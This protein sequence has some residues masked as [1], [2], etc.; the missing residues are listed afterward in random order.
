MGD[1]LA[2]V[3]LGSGKI[4]NQFA[5]GNGFNCMMNNDN[6]VRCFGSNDLGTLGIGNKNAVGDQ[7]N[8][9]GDNLVSI[10][11]GTSL[12]V[13]SIHLAST[14]FHSCAMFD[15]PKIKCWGHNRYG[16]LGYGD[17][18]N[19]G[20]DVNE[21]GDKLLFV[22]VGKKS[23]IK[24]V[25]VGQ[26]HTCALFTDDTTRCWGYNKQGQLGIGTWASVGIKPKQMGKALK[27]TIWG[28]LL[29]AEAIT[30]GS[31]ITCAL[32][33]GNILKC[34]GNNI[35]GQLGQGDM[36]NRGKNKKTIGDKV[37]PIDLGTSTAISKIQSG[38]AHT[39]V[40]FVDGAIK[41]FGFNGFGQ[42]GL[43]S[44][45]NYGNAKNQMGNNLPFVSL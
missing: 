37:L 38:S 15:G 44:T 33:N 30:L 1:N 10:D 12:V 2:F 41:C 18:N 24:N 17:T 19:R 27:L 21:M 31:G 7:P 22:D 4:V 9:M 40:L 36:K 29:H 13:K 11:F 6:K 43:G 23:V 5:S 3:D 26:L 8:E 28:K 39:C 42:L 34:F 14:A 16:Q 20:D 25:I 45:N 35:S 32:L